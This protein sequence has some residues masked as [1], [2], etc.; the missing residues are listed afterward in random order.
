MLQ[1]TCM[2]IDPGATCQIND[3]KLFVKT[4]SLKQPLEVTLG[5]GHALEAS[6]QGMVSLQMKLSNSKTRRCKLYDVSVSMSAEARKTVKLNEDGCHIIGANKKLF[7]LAYW[8]GSL[9]Y[10]HCKKWGESQQVNAANNQ[11][12]EKK[13]TTWHRRYGH[14]GVQI[15]PKIN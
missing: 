14:L 15:L 1:A 5:D 12:L 3:D 8:V 13:E 6:R 7:A 2:I 11:G 4:E 10:L 9:Y